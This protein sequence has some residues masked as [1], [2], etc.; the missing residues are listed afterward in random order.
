MFYTIPQVMN[1][2]QVSRISVY[3]MIADGRLPAGVK[4][5]A[6]RS[7]RV[8]FSKAAVDVAIARLTGVLPLAA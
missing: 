4:L 8:R 1:L 3:R 6:G 7:G 5:S 2:L